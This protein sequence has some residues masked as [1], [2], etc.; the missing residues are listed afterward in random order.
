MSQSHRKMGPYVRSLQQRATG[1]SLEQPGKGASGQAG[2]HAE[3][4]GRTCARTLE[5]GGLQGGLKRYLEYIDV[6]KL[7]SWATP[8]ELASR[9]KD[10]SPQDGLMEDSWPVGVRM[11]RQLW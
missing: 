3:P 5:T 11:V 10:L 1:T 8:A 6:P 2:R 4:H 9:I 7:Q